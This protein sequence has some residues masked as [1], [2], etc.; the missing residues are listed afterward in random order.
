VVMEIV[1]DV[2]TTEQGL[3]LKMEIVSSIF[4]VVPLEIQAMKPIVH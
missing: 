2:R 3:I 1:I 4:V